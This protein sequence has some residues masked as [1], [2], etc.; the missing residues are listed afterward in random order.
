M[1][2]KCVLALIGAIA[3]GAFL[4]K[5]LAKGISDGITFDSGS[6][7]FNEIRSLSASIT[8][9]LS[10]RNDNPIDIPINAFNGYLMYSGARISTLQLSGPVNLKSNSITSIQINSNISFVELAT[11]AVNLILNKSFNNNLRIVGVVNVKGV[12]ADIDYPLI[13]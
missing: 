7:K 12:N 5:K 2:F 11:D 8:V 13:G 3:L 9:L 1:R 4:L 10:F 6:I